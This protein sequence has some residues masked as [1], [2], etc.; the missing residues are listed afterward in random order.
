MPVVADACRR[1]SRWRRP[2]WRRHRCVKTDATKLPNSVAPDGMF[3]TNGVIGVA[4]PTAKLC[5]APVARGVVRGR[6][7]VRRQRAGAN[8]NERD[9][10]ATRDGTHT[11]R[12]GDDSR[13]AVT[14]ACDRRDEI[15]AV[16]RSRRDAC[17]A[18]PVDGRCR[19]VSRATAVVAVAQIVGRRRIHAGEGVG[20]GAR[21]LA[22]AIKRCIA[23]CAVDGSRVRVGHNPGDPAGGESARA[24]DRGGEGEGTPVEMPVALSITTVED[25]ASPTEALGSEP[26]LEV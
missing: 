4:S 26:E 14:S 22:A 17:D 5:G 12:S 23:D 24:S 6:A 19:V 1:R 9:R 11:C 7:G 18:R 10:E 8:S 16:G 20:D 2:R 3:V 15:P 25:P 13:C 21:G